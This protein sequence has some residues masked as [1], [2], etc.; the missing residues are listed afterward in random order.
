MVLI[1]GVRSSRHIGGVI[2]EPGQVAVRRN[3]G[4]GS[5]TRT[6]VQSRSRRVGE[7][8][9]Y[10]SVHKLVEQ[11]RNRT[12]IDFTVHSLRHTHANELI[13]SGVP[14]EVAASLL[15]H[16]SPVTTSQIYVHLGVEDLRVA[17]ERAGVWK[18]QR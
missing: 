4:Y 3:S 9:T 17:V 18:D 5:H 14:I 6:K 12:G 2:R 7:P 15:T 11:L 13:R 16:R 10:A 8:I 1:A